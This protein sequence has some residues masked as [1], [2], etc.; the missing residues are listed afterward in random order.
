MTPM[1]VCKVCNK[2]KTPGSKDWRVKSDVDTLAA[3]KGFVRLLRGLCETCYNERK[4]E[5][6]EQYQL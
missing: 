1:R 4:G 2:V 5:N 6:E 3:E